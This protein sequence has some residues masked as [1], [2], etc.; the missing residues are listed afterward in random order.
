MC[1]Q[2]QR[3]RAPDAGGDHGDADIQWS[4]L[5]IRE[6]PAGH[7]VHLNAAGEAS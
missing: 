4:G 5:R 2:L 1:F 7:R 3:A 6:G